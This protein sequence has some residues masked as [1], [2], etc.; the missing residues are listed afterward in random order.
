MYS[1]LWILHR[2]LQENIQ[3]AAVL[4]METPQSR[5]RSEENSQSGWTLTLSQII[6]LY[7][8]GEQNTGRTAHFPIFKSSGFSLLFLYRLVYI[9]MKSCFSKTMMEPRTVHEVQQT[10]V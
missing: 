6:T 9:G 2:M 10:T 4:C 7:K 5:A 3:G 8:H 1:S